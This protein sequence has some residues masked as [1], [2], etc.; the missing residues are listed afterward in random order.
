VQPAPERRVLA[1]AYRGDPLDCIGGVLNDLTAFGGPDKQ[2]LFILARGAVAA[3]GA[4]VANAA[5]VYA[6][7]MIAQG[8][9]R[10][11]K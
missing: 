4:D 11:A 3:D 2:T 5:Q 6:I 7:P 9:P 8:Y 10:R 1:N